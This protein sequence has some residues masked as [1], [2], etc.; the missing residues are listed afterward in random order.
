MSVPAARIAPEREVFHCLLAGQSEKQIARSLRISPNTVH[1][2]ASSIYHRF[3]VSGHIEL[4]AGLLASMPFTCAEVRAE[5]AMTR[6]PRQFDW[7]V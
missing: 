4:L 2:H 3:N 7:P 5:I 6:Q 1:H